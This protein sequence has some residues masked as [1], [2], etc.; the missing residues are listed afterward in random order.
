MKNEKLKRLVLAA[1][2]AALVFIATF[3]IKIPTI[4]TNG[5]VNIGDAVILVAAWFL[6]GFY[7]AAAAGIGAA[8]SDL[9]G[10]YGTYVPGTFGIKFVM[11]IVAFLIYK[12]I[13]KQDS[14]KT[15]KIFAYVLSGVV[16][17]SIMVLGYFGYEATV[18]HYGLAAAASIPSNIA[19]GVTSLVLALLLIL[20]LEK[21]KIYVRADKR[22]R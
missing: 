1:L 3:I 9:I 17:E 12:A 22:K 5:Y 11:A 7:G 2:F 14:S 4:G 10:G 20:A 6:G 8:L 13:A 18:L 19:Q 21:R 16:A 15:R